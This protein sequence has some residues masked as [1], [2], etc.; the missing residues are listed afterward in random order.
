MISAG[1]TS[2]LIN[3][4]P[5]LN[6]SD[7]HLAIVSQ[8]AIFFTLFYALLTNV[9]V[10]KKDKYD[11]SAFGYLLIFVNVIVVLLFFAQS[12]VK[13]WS[14]LMKKISKKYLHQS[15]LKGPPVLLTWKTFSRYFNKL[16]ESDIEQAAWIEIKKKEWGMSK[17]ETKKWLD[18]TWARAEWRS[19]TGDG[20]IDQMRVVFEIDVPFKKVVE[21]ALKT[22]ALPRG[23]F[24]SEVVRS[25]NVL[26][27]NDD[28]S[29]DELRV[30]NSPSI[31]WQV[32]V[33]KSC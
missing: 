25:I 26:G 11:K 3:W 32:S 12:F 1:S 16:I 19:S 5:Y 13:P 22:R 33:K 23:S 17:K 27:V 28:G 7:N 15:E 6:E 29:H 10:D 31:L 18:E 2:L 21:Y 8:V 14:A 9:G 4:K 20:P 30:I 24:K